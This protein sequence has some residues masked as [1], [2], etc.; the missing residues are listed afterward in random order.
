VYYEDWIIYLSILIFNLKEKIKMFWNNVIFEKFT[1]IYAL[2][3]YLIKFTLR[4]KSNN[5]TGHI[6]FQKV[7]IIY[8]EFF[9]NDRE[10]DINKYL[11]HL[12]A[13]VKVNFCNVKYEGFP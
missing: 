12:T 13:F 2:R 9:L 3:L 8:S 11:P 1:L 5:F 10:T 7:V 6:L 4:E